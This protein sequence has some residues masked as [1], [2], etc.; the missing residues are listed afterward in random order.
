MLPTLNKVLPKLKLPEDEREKRRLTNARRLSFC[1]DIYIKP[2]QRSESRW[3]KS[4]LRT[5]C[6]LT[7][8]ALA[9]ASLWGV[10]KLGQWLF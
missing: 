8:V 4:L 9:L 2:K 10:V 7:V 1:D 5:I 6:R 3:L